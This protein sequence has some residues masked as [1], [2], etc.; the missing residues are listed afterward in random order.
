M[1]SLNELVDYIHKKPIGH[2]QE[3]EKLR[4]RIYSP[5]HTAKSLRK[6]SGDIKDYFESDAPE[7]DKKKLMGYTEGLA[8]LMDAVRKGLIK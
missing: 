4:D 7:E 2:T 5:D 8:I 3:W 6:L 1:Y